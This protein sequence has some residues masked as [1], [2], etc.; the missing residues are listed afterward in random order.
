[1]NDDQED[2]LSMYY[3]VI[4][5]AEKHE[6]AWQP[7]PA[8]VTQYGNFTTHVDTIRD[9]AEDQIQGITGATRD[10]AQR[11]Q[12]MAE[13]AFPVA[14]AVQAWALENDN[15]EL[16]DR[17]GFS[18]SDFLNGRDT[19]AEER[20]QVVHDEGETNL[21]GLGDFGVTQQLLDDS[22]ATIDAYHEFLTAPREAITD[23]KAATAAMRVAFADADDVLKNRLDKLI[24]ILALTQ[25][26][27]ATDWRNARGVYDSGGGG[28][29]GGGSDDDSSSSSSESSLSSTSTS[30]EDSS[31]SFFSSSSQSSMS[32]IPSSSS[33]SA[34]SIPPPSSSSSLSSI[35]SFFSSSSSSFPVPP[36]SSSSSISSFFSSSSSSSFPLSSSSSDV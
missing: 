28:G 36:S 34:L 2:K 26:A 5:A 18:M 3:A 15:A 21:A 32:S 7:L 11:R 25:P 16:A 17:V 35:S 23:R 31:S 1:M 12:A 14:T 9:L 6:T 29:S 8:F 27:F 24:P 4:A 10:K 33:S 20:A 30:T 22:Q 19:I 13:L